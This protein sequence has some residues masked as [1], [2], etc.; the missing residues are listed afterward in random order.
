[1]SLAND[2]NL[3]LVFFVENIYH[4]ELLSKNPIL[5]CGLNILLLY[6]KYFAME[7]TRLFHSSFLHLKN[8]QLLDSLEEVFKNINTDFILCLKPEEIPEANFYS[9][10]DKITTSTNYVLVETKATSGL[11]NDNEICYEQRI[12][13]RDSPSVTS[14]Q[15]NISSEEYLPFKIIN[16]SKGFPELQHYKFETYVKLYNSENDLRYLSFLLK[17]GFN[18]INIEELE[19][20]FKSNYLGL[21][22]NEALELN[23][24]ISRKLIKAEKLPESV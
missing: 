22:Q 5:D 16:Y 15:N 19:K 18:R 6:P 12:F 1:M 21:T 24:E 14:N 17:Y 20:N 4:E 10:L 8:N 3:T 9:N 23:L 13:Y 2:K 11:K 7:Q